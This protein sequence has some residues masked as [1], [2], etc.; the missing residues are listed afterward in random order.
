MAMKG[1]LLIDRGVGGAR[2][3]AIDESLLLSCEEGGEGFPCLRFYSWE[4][5]T[6]T[7]GYNQKKTMLTPDELRPLG[8]DLVR[9]PTGGWAVLHQRE[10]TYSFVA[11]IDDSFGGRGLNDSV[12]MIAEALR[13]GLGR[14]GIEAAVAGERTRPSVDRKERSSTPCFFLTSRHELTFGGR[15]IVGSAQRRLKSS[16]LQHGSVPIGLDR[17]LFERVFRLDGKGLMR[18]HLTCLE[19]I[20]G[21]EVSFEEVAVALADGFSGVFD[22]LFEEGRLSGKESGMVEERERDQC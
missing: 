22:T 12:R 13:E 7:L 18:E 3:M 10:L 9:R 2:N 8:V 19:E 15:K 16:F 11:R 20:L 17:E 4:R 21:R 6:V 5:P 14:L 1:R